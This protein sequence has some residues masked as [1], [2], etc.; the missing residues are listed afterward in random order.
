MSVP[1]ACGRARSLPR[2]VPWK[3]LA[4]SWLDLAGRAQRRCGADRD[5]D[6]GL[7]ATGPVVL[8][9]AGPL[10][11][12]VACQLLEAGAEVAAVVQTAPAKT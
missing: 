10:L 2:P 7:S 9:G 6:L 12:L 11:L 8:A 4:G 1:H 3:A 5:E